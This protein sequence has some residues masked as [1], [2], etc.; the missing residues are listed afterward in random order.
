MFLILPR[1]M[2]VWRPFF[3]PFSVS[4]TNIRA[5]GWSELMKRHRE[6]REVVFPTLSPPAI[7]MHSRVG[8]FIK[9]LADMV[10][11]PDAA[12]SHAWA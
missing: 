4:M 12:A 10:V 6:M 5:P 7:R 9:S 1:N 2:R 3:Q 8:A 11:R